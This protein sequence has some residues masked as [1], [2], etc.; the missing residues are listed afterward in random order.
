MSVSVS[1]AAIQRLTSPISI[2][3]DVNGVYQSNFLINLG[4]LITQTGSLNGDDQNLDGR[5]QSG[6]TLDHDNPNFIL[7]PI[8]DLENADVL[9]VGKMSGIVAGLLV[10]YPVI[11][12]QSG[13]SQFLIYPDGLPDLL[14]GAL[15]TVDTVLTFYEGAGY[16]PDGPIPCFTAGALI[17]TDDGERPVETLQVGDLVATKDH[18]LQPIRWIGGRLVSVS[19]MRRNVDLR[20]IRISAGAMGNG[21]PR[22]DLLVSPHHRVLIRSKIAQ[23]M[24][25]SN[26]ILVAVDGF[27]IDEG[28]DLVMYYHLLLDRHEVIFANGAETESLY[29]GPQGMNAIGPDAARE[30]VAIF[31]ELGEGGILPNP[32][33]MLIAGRHGR[34]LAARHVRNSRHL[35]S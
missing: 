11:L 25:G 14:T 8:P 21:H 15:G 13:G 24:F 27:E 33:R 3:Y 31:P 34:N 20:P 35:V 6:E 22:Q 28:D 19:A 7:D 18:G 29:P 23:R 9:A 30:I 10:D 12:V 32:A 2:S 17:L 1:G 5:I 16:D 4:S 26:E